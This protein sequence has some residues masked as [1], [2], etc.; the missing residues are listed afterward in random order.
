MPCFGSDYLRTK[1]AEASKREQR[2]AEALRWYADLENYTAEYIPHED[3]QSTASILLDEGERARTALAGTTPEANVEFDP[4]KTIDQELCKKEE[5][6]LCITCPL[7]GGD[8]FLIM[9][10]FLD[11]MQVTCHRCHGCK[12]IP[13]R[14]PH[15]P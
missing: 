4:D 1:L 10:S 2:L 3:S 12:E 5:K 13:N 8:G 15:H 9:E 7:C 11:E 6:P 14:A